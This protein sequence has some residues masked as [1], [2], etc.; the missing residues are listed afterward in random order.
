MIVFYRGVHARLWHMTWWACDNWKPTLS[1]SSPFACMWNLG[2]GLW[3]PGLCSKCLPSR[4]HQ[5]PL[6][7]FYSEQAR[8]PG[9][10]FPLQSSYPDN[11]SQA[12]PGAHLIKIV[13]H[14]CACRLASEVTPNPIKLA[15]SCHLHKDQY[16]EVNYTS[17]RQK[18]T[19]LKWN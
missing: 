4:S 16:F 14:R 15:I 10:I 6:A 19:T 2:L 7:P 8:H 13:P 5:A 17:M 12:C 1:W 9:N 11:P 3:S 18:W